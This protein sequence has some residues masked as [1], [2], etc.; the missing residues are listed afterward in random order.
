MVQ[1]EQIVAWA[2][3]QGAIVGQVFE[4]LD[5][6]GARADRPLLEAAIKRVETGTSD[7]IVVAKLDRFGRS[8]LDALQAIERIQT[9]GGSFVSVQDGRDLTTDTGKL[10]LRIMFS[11]AEWELDRVRAS[12]DQPR[13]KAIERGVYVSACAPTGYV[14]GPDG[15]LVPDPVTAPAV[16]EAFRLRANRESLPKI[17]GLLNDRGVLTPYG[18]QWQPVS[19]RRVFSRRAYLGEA[20]TGPHVNRHAHP[21]LIDP[22]SKRSTRRTRPTHPHVVAGE[23]Q[24]HEVPWLDC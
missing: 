1:R 23:H 10:V 17:S 19:L 24:R 6:S 8:L 18:N 20:K 16:V 2:R 15:R 21:A 11:M 9:A 5:E 7:G 13:A 14:K 4:E 12:W 22:A 3:L